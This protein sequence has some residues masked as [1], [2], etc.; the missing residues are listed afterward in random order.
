[1]GH[2]QFCGGKC[3]PAHGL[4]QVSTNYVGLHQVHNGEI[5]WTGNEGYGKNIRVQ[6]GRC[7]VRSV[8]EEA[9]ESL[10]RHQDKL[11]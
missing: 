2:H 8:F 7:P 5:P 3:R 9:L 10:K 1:M 11:G 6:M 4:H